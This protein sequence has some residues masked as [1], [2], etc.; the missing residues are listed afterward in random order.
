MTILNIEWP[1][2]T[3]SGAFYKGWIFLDFKSTFV[4]TATSAPPQISLCWRML[5]LNPGESIAT[6]AL[7]PNTWLDL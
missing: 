2:L 7:A 1:L 3:L 5:G 4:N 6:L